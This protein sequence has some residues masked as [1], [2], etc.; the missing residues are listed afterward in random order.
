MHNVSGALTLA[1][2]TKTSCFIRRRKRR[3]KKKQKQQKTTTTTTRIKNE[4]K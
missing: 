3:R 4:M 1:K 2:K